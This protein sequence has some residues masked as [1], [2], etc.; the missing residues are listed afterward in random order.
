MSIRKLRTGWRRAAKGRDDLALV[1]KCLEAGGYKKGIPVD[2][3]PYRKR[4]YYYE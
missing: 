2:S 4:A 1:I 3:E